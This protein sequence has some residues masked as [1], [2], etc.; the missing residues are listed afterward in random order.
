[1]TR[2]L[3]NSTAGFIK[4]IRKITLPLVEQAIKTLTYFASDTIIVS[5]PHITIT[6][7]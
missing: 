3:V 5:D 1:M 7:T 6:E 2:D 4:Y